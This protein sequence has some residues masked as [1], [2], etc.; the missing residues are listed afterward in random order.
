MADYIQGLGVPDALAGSEPPRKDSQPWQEA[1]SGGAERLHLNMAKSHQ[2]DPEPIT[3]FD[4]DA[5]ISKATSL[6]A[7]RGLRFSYYPRSNRNLNKPIH[8]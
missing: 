5:F 2:L 8:I 4:V 7:L 6:E 3:Q 1:L